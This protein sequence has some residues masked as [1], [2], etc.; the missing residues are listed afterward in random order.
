MCLV[1]NVRSGSDGSSRPQFYFLANR[2]CSVGACWLAAFWMLTIGCSPPPEGFT[3]RDGQPILETTLTPDYPAGRKRVRT[4]D[5]DAKTFSAI[6]YAADSNTR[7]LEYAKDKTSVF[8]AIDSFPVRLDKA[9]PGSFEVLTSDGRYARDDRHVYYCG[10][11][12]EGAEAAGFEVLA[13]PYSKDLKQVYV[14]AEVLELADAESFVVVMPGRIDFPWIQGGGPGIA[15]R[16]DREG[17]ETRVTGWGRDSKQFFCGKMAVKDV[18]YESFTPL[19][20]FYAKDDDAVYYCDG[21]TV[22]RV[23]AD[24]QTFEVDG[25][26]VS[27][28]DRYR[29]FNQG[30]ARPR[31]GLDQ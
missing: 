13:P 6:T 10:V 11:R 27:A 17:I 25:P 12:L 28:H 29:R 9:S 16:I 2:V 1:W 19:N 5:A 31:T 4:I 20:A 7:A 24:P 3:V 22:T 21:R 23:T 14:G 30:K 26:T 15:R 8:V 18:D